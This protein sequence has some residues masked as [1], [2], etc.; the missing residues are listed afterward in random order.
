M[1]LNNTRDS[2]ESDLSLVSKNPK[3]RGSK[4]VIPSKG[5]IIAKRNPKK[6]FKKSDTELVPVLDRYLFRFNSQ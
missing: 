2:A 1:N 3:R 4:S 5:S 6:K